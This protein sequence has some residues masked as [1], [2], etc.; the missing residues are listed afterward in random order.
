MKIRHAKEDELKDIKN[1]WNYCFNDGES[2]VE[3]YFKDKYKRHNTIVVEDEGEV[4][5]SLQLN[6]Y[7]INLNNKIYNTS[8][9]VGVSTLPQVRGRGYM[10][11]IMKFMLKELYRKNQLVSILMPIDYRLYR[12]YGYEHCY[13]QIEYNINIEDLSSYKINGKLYKANRYNINEL[14]DISKDFLKDVNGNVERDDKFYQSLLEE[15]KSENGHI[16]IHENDG[17]EGYIIYFLDGETMFVREIY[18]KNMDSLKSMLKFIYNHNTQCKK[19]KISAP[20][21]DKIKFVLDNPRTCDIKI[22]PFM[23]GRIINLKAYLESLTIKSNIEGS[24]NILVKDNY[25]E[26]NNGVFK[27]QIKNNR[28]FVEKVNEKHTVSFNINTLT[29]LA[30][31]YIDIDEAILLNDLKISKRDISLLNYI[32]KKRNNYINEYV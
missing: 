27:I 26:N 3:Y 1:I 7:K 18:Y 19:V 29:Q 16:Y 15:I 24:L 12:K 4:V 30:F 10:K 20:I 32:F 2:F 13:D 31:S 22:K 6:Q 25:I 11:N 28:L 9:V 21:N 14:V 8:Y 5:S 23:M 17:S